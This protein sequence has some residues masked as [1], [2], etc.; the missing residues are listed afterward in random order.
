MLT[1]IP[2]FS[3]VPEPPVA[4]RDFAACDQPAAQGDAFD[5]LLASFRQQYVPYSA[6]FELT[7]V[8]NLNCVMCYNVPLAEPELS[9]G[10]W[11]DVLEQAAAAGTLHLTLSGGEILTRRDFF[12]IAGHARKL[13]F[14]LELKTNGTLLTPE[15]ADQI[16]ALEPLKVDISLLGASDATFDAVAGSSRSFT[17]MLRGV[18]LLQERAIPVKLN[19][20]LL[21]L[22]VSDRS[23]MIDLA[24]ELGVECSLVLK[25][26]SDDVGFDR[27]DAYKLTVD[28]MTETL[29]ADQTNIQVKVPTNET[30][31]CS[32]GLSSFLVSPYGEVYPCNELRISAGNIRQERFTGI[33]NDAPIFQ[34]LRNRHTYA[35]LPECRVCPLNAYCFGRCSGLAWKRVGNLYSADLTA[36]AHAQAHYQM[37]HPGQPVPMTPLQA[38]QAA[39]LQPS[40]FSA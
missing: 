5:Q 18:R 6:L 34:E 32:V 36:C 30:R 39:Q 9:T 20:L 27:A 26:S 38:K 21:N 4:P 13:G 15:S 3:S 25:V 2:L 12:T 19:T 8:C 7:H 37:R 35:N 33:W 40:V 24:Q 1:T 16:A 22:N 28:Q 14:V 17:R 23:K 29:V 11:L 10:E 31:T